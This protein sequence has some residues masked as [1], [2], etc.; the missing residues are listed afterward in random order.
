[1]EIVIL[2]EDREK[3]RSVKSYL[4]NLTNLQLETGE[5]DAIRVEAACHSLIALPILI[6]GILIVGRHSIVYRKKDIFKRIQ[7]QAGFKFL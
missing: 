5:W 1:M 4:L 7:C 6:G 2:W 3:T